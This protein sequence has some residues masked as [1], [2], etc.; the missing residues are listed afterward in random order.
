[1]DLG[2]Q[3]RA[4]PTDAGS[5]AVEARTYMGALAAIPVDARVDEAVEALA[6]LHDRVGGKR[7]LARK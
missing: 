4:W 7:P 1:M 6:K 5:L 2:T 3:T